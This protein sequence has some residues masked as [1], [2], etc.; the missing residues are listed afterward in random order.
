[1]KNYFNFNL[2]GK[3]LFP[4][5][6]LSLIFFIVPYIII[7]FHLNGIGPGERPSL[8]IIPF[9]ILLIIMPS[10]LLFYIVKFLIEALSFKEKNIM[11]DGTFGKYAGIFLSGLFLS[12]ITLGIYAPWMVR[13][14]NRF[15]INNSSYESNPFKF[16]GSGGKLF[17]IIV[18]TL[19][20]PVIIISAVM[21]AF[22]IENRCQTMELMII[23]EIIV[24]II[25]IPCIYLIYKWM[26]DVDYKEYHI[27]WETDF[28]NSC[29][30]IAIEVLLTI[31]TIGIYW[32]LA[33]LRLYK[34]FIERT[35]ARSDN[36]KLTFGYDIAQ[37]RD[38][39]FIW[40]QALLTAITVWIY[41]PWAVSKI[42]KRVI[43]KTY[44]S[45]G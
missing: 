37:L 35:V 34:Y 4:V 25:S 21:A 27:V 5:W 22:I 43:G 7:L 30:K 11:F 26:I 45:E 42:G 14:I 10:L 31:I 12:I 44:I 38:F 19:I 6:V 20:L 40:G 9:I 3:K 17:G 29:G 39:L 32:P 41:F 36:T 13:N 16:K 2:S 1:M 24:M 8:I 15:F 33:Y 28:W 18:L 23:Q